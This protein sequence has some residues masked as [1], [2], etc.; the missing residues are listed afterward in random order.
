M[1]ASVKNQLMMEDE[2]NENVSVILNFLFT[3]KKAAGDAVSD[4]GSTVKDSLMNATVAIHDAAKVSS[5]ECGI[6]KS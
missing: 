6:C 2:E 4:A 1:V 3:I 5:A